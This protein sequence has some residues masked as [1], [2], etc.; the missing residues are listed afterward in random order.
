[1]ILFFFFALMMFIHIVRTWNLEKKTTYKK[2]NEVVY[3]L[4]TLAFGVY[5][6]LLLLIRTCFFLGRTIEKHPM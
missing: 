3:A 5:Y 2:I 6:P 1:M 4:L